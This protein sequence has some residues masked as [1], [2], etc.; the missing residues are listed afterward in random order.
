MRRSHD[1]LKPRELQS[2]SNCGIALPT[3]VVC[4]NCGTYMKRVIIKDEQAAAE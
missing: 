2:C 3:H 4:P 1:A